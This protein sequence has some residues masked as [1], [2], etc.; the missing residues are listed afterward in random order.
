VASG[1]LGACLSKDSCSAHDRDLQAASK[2]ALVQVAGV[3]RGTAPLRSEET[4][5][6][7]SFRTFCLS[8]FY[9]LYGKWYYSVVRVGDLLA[10]RPVGDACGV[11]RHRD[12]N[13]RF[14]N[15]GSKCWYCTLIKDE[16]VVRNNSLFHLSSYV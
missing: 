11:V 12:F 14:P 6:Q 8:L 9:I 4:L 13:D 5:A 10:H 16:Q 7:L 1:F 2:D 15:V 3:S